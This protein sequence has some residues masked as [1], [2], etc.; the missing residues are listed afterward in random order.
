MRLAMHEDTS[1]GIDGLRKRMI[2]RLERSGLLPV[3]ASR[4]PVRTPAGSPLAVWFDHTALKPEA[5]ESVFTALCGEARSHGVASVCVPPNRVEQAAELLR[6]TEVKVCTVIG[7]PLGYSD[8]RCKAEEVKRALKQG[9]REFDTVIPV[10]IAK[11]GNWEAL[12]RDI[13]RTVEAAEGH[14]VKVIL[15]T[16]LLT[17]EEKILAGITSLLAGAHFLKTSTGF[18]AGGATLEDVRLLRAVAGGD[19]G[20]KASG[21]IRDLAFTRALIQAGADRIGASATVKILAE[22]EGEKGP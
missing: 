3:P 12:F 16:C 22:A 19:R 20:V 10:G 11:D 18:S 4:I 6:G 15:E 1:V 7:F 2:L 9:C 14:L 17:E 8:S 21:G 5:D 13:R